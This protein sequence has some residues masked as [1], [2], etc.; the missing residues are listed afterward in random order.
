MSK[1]FPTCELS[2]LVINVDNTL[3]CSAGWELREVIFP[4]YELSG[5][6]LALW[7]SATAAFLTAC[8]ACKGL[9]RT[10][11]NAGSSN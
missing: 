4:M 8:F 2:D 1:V 3:S 9:V 11:F 6:D 10:I 5:S 7:M